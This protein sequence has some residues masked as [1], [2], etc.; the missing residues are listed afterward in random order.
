MTHTPGHCFNIEV[1]SNLLLLQLFTVTGSSGPH[2]RTNPLEWPLDHVIHIKELLS[3]GSEC[4]MV[5]EPSVTRVDGQTL[6]G[7]CSRSVKPIAHWRTGR[8][9]D[10]TV[11]AGLHSVVYWR[12]AVLT[13][14]YTTSK[15]VGT[16]QDW[17]RVGGWTRSWKA[18][19][20]KKYQTYILTYIHQARSQGG[21]GGGGSY[22]PPPV[23]HPKD[24]VPPFSNFV[25]PFRF[26]LSAI[27]FHPL[28]ILFH[29][30]AILFHPLAI[31]F[32]PLAILFQGGGQ[33]KPGLEWVSGHRG[34]CKPGLGYIHTHI[35]TYIHTYT[36]YTHI[37]IY[38]HTYIH[39]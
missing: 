31:L 7:Q 23:A 36:L 38:I 17:L 25:P 10:K 14:R 11:P 35:L 19:Q 30:L 9:G 8:D 1:L 18:G 29:P 39:I 24:F 32:H 27:L 13:F 12:W 28:A 2:E 34:G 21:V 3:L 4:L 6:A 20:S 37:H 15:Q 33:G 22:D 26:H 16:G 5:V